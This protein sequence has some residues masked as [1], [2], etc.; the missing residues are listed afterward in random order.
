MRDNSD[1][2]QNETTTRSEVTVRR[3]PRY[4]RFVITTIVIFVI[5]SFFLTYSRPAV[6]QF[7]SNQVFGYMILVSIVFGIIVGSILALVIDKLMGRTARTVLAEKTDARVEPE[8][9][10][11]EPEAAES[12]TAAT[13]A[14]ATDDA[15]D[16]ATAEAT[17]ASVPAERE[18]TTASAPDADDS[19]SER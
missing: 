15:T 3:S 6:G 7:S 18:A 12:A 11:S 19:T 4:G 9:A 1:V 5:A 10:G 13:G 2:Q 16:A 8:H 17:P 14:P